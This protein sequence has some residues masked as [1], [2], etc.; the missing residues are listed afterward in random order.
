MDFKFSH[1]YKQSALLVTTNWIDAPPN[2]YF[3]W[4]KEMINKHWRSKDVPR[5]ARFL[6]TYD[7]AKD[8]IKLLIQS[9]DG[10]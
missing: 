9:I 1:I 7:S 5:A 4:E 8:A 10:K 3:L 6:N 2:N